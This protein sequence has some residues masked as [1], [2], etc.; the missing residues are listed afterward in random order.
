MK[1]ASN[2]TTVG[3]MG[4]AVVGAFIA[5]DRANA[6]REASSGGWL[7]PSAPVA[8]I[9]TAD[10]QFAKGN[11]GDPA[12]A[13][14][15]KPDLK[16][17]E[18]L[19]E[20]REA[21]KDNFVKPGSVNDT[22]LTY[23]AV[24]GMLRALGDRF[25]RFLTPEEY[26]EFNER[27][28][29]EFT[30]IGARIDIKDDYRGGPQAKPFG[31]SRPY[32]VEPIEGSP[33]LQAGLK[34]D[35]VILAIN[36][37]STADLSDEATVA[38][39]RGIRGTTVKVKVERLIPTKGKEKADDSR[40][41]GS[42]DGTFQ[43]L[44]LEIRR[45]IIEMHPVKLEWLPG[46]IAWLRLDEFNKKTDT[47][48]GNALREVMKGNA[49]KPAKGLLFDLRNNPGGLLD[50]AVD[51]GSRFISTGPIVYTRERDGSERALTAEKNRF[52]NLKIPVVVM[53][54]RY[55]AS[56]AEIVSGAIKD[57]NAGTIVGETSFGKASVQNLVELKNGG[58]LVITTAKY[59]T[60]NKTDISE[61]GVS[62]DVAV[63][64]SD[65]DDK[66][67]KGAQLQKAVAVITEK[68]GKAPT[69]V[70]QTN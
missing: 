40:R 11:L 38:A 52:M 24:R 33:A 39:I 12:R 14:A 54:N 27:N 64:A 48:M 31:A 3:L 66:S 17:Y 51:V 59:L 23:G 8:L 37:K 60:P 70:A 1:K 28:S 16:P 56:A 42:S 46:D 10:G 30:G 13:R 55:S 5:G 69:T 45:D 65:E 41:D 21:I 68:I 53:V 43:V 50:A 63:K 61:K 34:K 9:R 19:Y 26:D 58:A 44:D 57:R 36:G 2:H 32:V 7:P 25:T 6:W 35:D 67:G 20:V 29:A 47:E 15:A 18:T 4:L 22:Q 49:G 62:P